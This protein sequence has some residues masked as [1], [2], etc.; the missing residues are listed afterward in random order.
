MPGVA[1]DPVPVAE[2]IPAAEADEVL[3]AVAVEEARTGVTVRVTTE[4]G[5]HVER[6]V[7]SAGPMV[8][9]AIVEAVGELLASPAP[10]V[11]AVN[12][13]LIDGTE[14]ILVVVEH[15][16]GRRASGSSVMDVGRPFA[17][18]SAAWRAVSAQV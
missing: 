10:T 14:V 1:A 13:H 15:A 9:L 5:R 12:D 4:L 3:A 11:V 16:D 8:D 6:S 2:S 18:G 17:V 7:S